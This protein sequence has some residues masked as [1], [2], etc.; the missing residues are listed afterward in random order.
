MGNINSTSASEMTKNSKSKEWVT[1]R[2]PKDTIT[3]KPRVLYLFMGSLFCSFLRGLPKNWGFFC[4]GQSIQEWTKWNLWKTV[5][6]KLKWYGL[7]R[8]IITTIT[9]SASRPCDV[10][11]VCLTKPKPY[12][13]THAAW[14]LKRHKGLC[15]WMRKNE[16]AVVCNKLG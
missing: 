12:S 10:F 4:M 1:Y 2:F 13:K 6:K 5:F 14:L 11:P 7:L 9:N 3:K 16:E 8:Q 15:S